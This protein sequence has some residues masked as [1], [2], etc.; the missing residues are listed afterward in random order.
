MHSEQE[1]NLSGFKIA[2]FS[3]TSWNKLVQGR[4]M[5]GNP[6]AYKASI[7]CLLFA[8]L[9]HKLHEVISEDRVV[10]DGIR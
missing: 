10:L 3:P 4:A 1:D 6:L 2:N 5:A 7:G 8:Y 9:T